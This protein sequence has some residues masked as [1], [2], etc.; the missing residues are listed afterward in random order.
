VYKKY[1]ILWNVESDK[2][3]IAT[4]MREMKNYLRKSALKGLTA[5]CVRRKMKI[6]KTVYSHELNKIMTSKKVV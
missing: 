3:I 5:D 1:E 6:I 4:E 2:W